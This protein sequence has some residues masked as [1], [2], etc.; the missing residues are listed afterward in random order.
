MSR[1]PVT[2]LL[3]VAIVAIFGLQ[4]WGETSGTDLV[5]LGANE[6]TSVLA[7][8]YWR[9]L[10]SMFLHGGFLHLA[11]NAWG[12]YQLGTLFESWLGSTRMLGTYFVSGIAGSVASIVWTQMP[13][14][15]ASGAIFGLLG[16]L[17]AFLLKRHEALSPQG[18]SILSQLVM[19]AVINVFIGAST[20]GIDN[21]AHLGGCAAGFLI[22]LLLRE[23]GSYRSVAE[24]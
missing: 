17:I 12:L 14:V 11:L 7:G 21:A 1:A 6:R 22:G 23:R 8:Q 5:A 4:I 2:K 3:L 16:A 19:W 24:A 15:G 9:L 10:T 18:K 20:P 13:S